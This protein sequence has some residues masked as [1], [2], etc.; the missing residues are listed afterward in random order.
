METNLYWSG[1]WPVCEMSK[2]WIWIVVEA[3]ANAK[4]IESFRDRSLSESTL[5]TGQ[6]TLMYSRTVCTSQIKVYVGWDGRKLN[7]LEKSLQTLPL[8]PTPL[9]SIV[10]WYAEIADLW[11]LIVLYSYP[12][13]KSSPRK[14]KIGVISHETG[15]VYLLWYQPTHFLQADS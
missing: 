10:W 5:L 2:C 9:P 1:R 13:S 12:A 8:E 11:E 15:S 3:E 4:S 6:F 14:S 7:I